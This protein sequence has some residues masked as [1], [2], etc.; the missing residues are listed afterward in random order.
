MF[1]GLP[2]E[3][4]QDQL[5]VLAG[6]SLRDVSPLLAADALLGVDPLSLLD[7]DQSVAEEV[8]AQLQVALNQVAALQAIVIEAVARRVEHDV[9][10]AKDSDRLAGHF[11]AGWGTGDDYTPSVLAPLLHLPPRTMAGRLGEARVLVNELPRTLRAA[12][13]GDLEPWRVGACLLYTS[14]SPRDS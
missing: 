5:E 1:E 4:G 8:V 13:D 12:L 6:R 9:E 11:P 3:A 7:L 14:P 10:L 2:W